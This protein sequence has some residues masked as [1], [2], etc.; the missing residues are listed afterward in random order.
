MS[1]R[2]STTGSEIPS[3][4]APTAR[5]RRA[6]SAVALGITTLLASAVLT[7][8]SNDG[9][10]IDADYAKV[11]QDK[12][13]EERVDDD[14]CSEGGR[15]IGHAGWYFYPITSSQRVPAVGQRLSGGSTRLPAGATSKS[16]V[17]SDGGKV[18]RGGFGDS[19][20]GGSGG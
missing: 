15:S 19:A 11:C 10:V 4:P 17:S 16:G 5:R 2:T 7:G 3:L 14:N 12:E 18:T 20:K 13:T 9:E 8:C 6:S 1:E